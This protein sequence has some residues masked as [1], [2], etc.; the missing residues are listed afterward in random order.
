MTSQQI[1]TLEESDLFKT[2]SMLELQQLQVQQHWAYKRMTLSSVA[3]VAVDNV[4]LN[5]SA[6]GSGVAVSRVVSIDTTSRV[7]SHIPVANSEGGY[8]DFANK[9]CICKWKL[10]CSCNSIKC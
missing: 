5:A 2:H 4:I 6:D 9:Q 3:D 10:N 8:A 7:V 1:M